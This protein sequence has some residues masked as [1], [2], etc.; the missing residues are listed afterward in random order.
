M[1]SALEW[2]E[3]KTLAAAGLSQHEIARRLGINRR[4]QS[5]VGRWRFTRE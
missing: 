1:R 2:A 3:A 5:V 4:T